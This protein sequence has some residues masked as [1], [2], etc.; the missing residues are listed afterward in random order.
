[1]QRSSC[2]INQSF[3]EFLIIF[4]WNDQLLKSLFGI[5]LLLFHLGKS[6]YCHK[7]HQ[8]FFTVFLLPLFACISAMLI[9]I[10]CYQCLSSI[11][12]VLCICF[13]GFFAAAFT[14]CSQDSSTVKASFHGCSTVTFLFIFGM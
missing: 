11:C 4:V 7:P 10:H 2:Q 5:L 8:S 3:S 13:T 14:L 6:S 12:Y 1:M 9:C